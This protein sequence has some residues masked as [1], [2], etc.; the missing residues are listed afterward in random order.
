[1]IQVLGKHYALRPG[2]KEL[3][4]R[5]EAPA[6]SPWGLPPEFPKLAVYSDYPCVKERFQAMDLDPGPMLRL[7]GPECF[8]AQKPA[9][10]PFQCIAQDMG[11]QPEEVLVV[12]DREDTDGH[13]AFSA[14]MRFF[15][16][17]TGRRRHFR[18]DPYR[19]YP[20]GE[21]P[22]G[23]IL[24]MYSGAWDELLGV[25]ENHCLSQRL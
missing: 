10:R 15:C 13:G 8:G 3:L 5:L 19:N 16:L 6:G 4:K 7:Y 11:L 22:S 1:M 25:I 17:E 18:L 12:G 21:Q 20:K 9:Q 24:P 14:G 23:P 2:L